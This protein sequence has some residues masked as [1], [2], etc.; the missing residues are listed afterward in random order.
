MAASPF[1]SLRGTQD[2]AAC[3]GTGWKPVWVQGSLGKADSPDPR[4]VD[5]PNSV[6]ARLS[7]YPF[8]T[9]HASDS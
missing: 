3:R 1:G 4:R 8:S 2:M 6:G 5:L 9:P 7:R